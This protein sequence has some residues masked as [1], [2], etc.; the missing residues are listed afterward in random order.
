MGRFFDEEVDD[1]CRWIYICIWWLICTELSCG[2]KLSI[3][4]KALRPSRFPIALRVFSWQTNRNLLE[5]VCLCSKDKDL[6]LR[7]LSL[8]WRCDLTEAIW[9]LRTC[10]DHYIWSS[11]YRVVFFSR[12]KCDHTEDRS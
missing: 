1:A 2:P 9:S 6:K 11:C 10:Y 8:M 4:G 5:D 3:S 7:D 12:S